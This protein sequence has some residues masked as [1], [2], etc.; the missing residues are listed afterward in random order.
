MKKAL[1]LCLSVLIVGG[2]YGCKKKKDPPANA[3]SVLFVNGCAGTDAIDSK[4]D[5]K[6]VSGAEN[7]GFTANS[8]YKYVTAAQNANISF[9]ITNKGTPIINKTVTIANGGYYSAFCGGPITAPTFLL[10]TDDRSAPA[11]NT[12]KVRFVNLSSVSDSLNVTAN[13]SAMM[14]DSNVTSQEV[15]SYVQVPAGTYELK[16]GDP[17][18]LSTVV[19]TGSASLGAGKIYT[20]MMTGNKM[21]TG[22][23]ALKLTV[24]A[25]N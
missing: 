8:G 3:G 1:V 14:I 4:V 24:I 11:P 6:A 19:S 18:D 23:S 10:T 5:Y 12:A 20:L 15:T 22:Q 2:F 21:G 25:N 9:Y 17:K 16:A 7:L 13:A